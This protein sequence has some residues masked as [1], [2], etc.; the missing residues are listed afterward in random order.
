MASDNV[1]TK[2]CGSTPYPRTKEPWGNT[3]A[4]SI[5]IALVGYEGVQTLDLAGPLD[6][7]GA[8]NC[9]RPDAYSMCVTNLDGRPLASETGLRMMPDC[10]L[11]DAG[12]IDTVVVP[13]GDAT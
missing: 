10:A 1:G 8:V 6:A 9:A 2:T 11:D 4:K 13:G 5:R 3:S 12:W 7:F